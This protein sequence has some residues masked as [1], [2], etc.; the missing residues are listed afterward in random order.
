MRK[1]TGKSA[2]CS[3][4]VLLSILVGLAVYFMVGDGRQM[5]LQMQ[6]PMNYRE[7]VEKYAVQNDL[8]PYLVYA[9]IKTES[10]FDTEAVSHAGAHGLMQLM[11][12]TAQDS[13]KK[14]KISVQLPE[15][16]HDPDKNVMLGTCYLKSLLKSYDSLELALAA[17]NGGTGNVQKWLKDETLS[18][19]KGGLAQIPFE[20]TEKYVKKVMHAYEQYKSLYGSEN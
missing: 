3:V 12:E 14:L 15:D 8:D 16:L 17:Y 6:Y 13:A 4:I 1:K 18:D 9:V 19:G 11:E 2:G 20:E 7:I 5:I 10:R